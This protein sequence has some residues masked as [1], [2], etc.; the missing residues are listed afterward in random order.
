MKK[1]SKLLAI[2]LAVACIISLVACAANNSDGDASG[3]ASANASSDASNDATSA[4]KSIAEILA[5]KNDI[6][7]IDETKPVGGVYQI[8]TKEGV[9]SMA[10]HPEASF[11]ILCSIDMEGEKLTPIGDEKTPFTGRIDGGYFT[12][13]NFTIEEPTSDG[14][15]G[16]IGVNKGTVSNLTFKN[17]KI[18]TTANTK[19]VGLLAGTS[20]G[21]LLRNSSEECSVEVAKLAEGAYVGQVAGICEGELQDNIICLDT[22][23][24]SDSSATIGGIAAKITNA[25]VD[26]CEAHGKVDITGG[27]N[28]TVGLFAGESADSSFK[29]ASYISTYNKVD[30]ALYETLIA[31]ETNVT[32]EG[33]SCVDNDKPE[34]SAEVAEKRQLVCDIMDQLCLIPWRVRQNLRHS[35]T[36]QLSSCHGIYNANVQ[37]YGIP[38]N[39]KSCSIY[40]AKYIIDDEGYLKDWVYD[41]GDFDTF[42]VYFGSDCSGTVMRALSAVTTQVESA[43]TRD[44]FPTAGKGTVAVGDWVY[45]Y[46][47]GHYTSETI[48]DIG[49]QAIYECYAQARYG[50]ITDYQIEAGGHVR[51]IVEDPVVV[52]FED[53]TIDG[54]RSYIIESE[55]GATE[56]RYADPTKEYSSCRSHWKYTFAAL[57]IDGALPITLPEF[58]TGEFVDPAVELQDHVDYSGYIGICNGTV[59]SNLQLD[60]VFM[61]I[62]DKDGN[63][64]FNQVMFTKVARALEE[65]TSV[66]RSMCTTFDLQRFAYPIAQAGVEFTSG[67]TY[68]VKLTAGLSNEVEYDVATYQVEF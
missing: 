31:K 2:I 41:A 5:E 39:H 1:I 48:N 4:T 20:T 66:E 3:D 45:T 43:N 14:N 47:N 6:S 29:N 18:V 44:M 8:H 67:E 40:R 51:M 7:K 35:C 28:K 10:Q 56:Q 33:C 15:M 50:D 49:E 68:N 65:G 25:T 53:G 46:V 54:A 26:A 55:E 24:T 58:V 38:Y 61:T 23:C 21:K 57:V 52:R 22:T 13:S 34:L 30:G 59:K 42:D 11:T 27:A 36:C 19:A 63:E 64:L 9:K 60:R 37:Y 12:I 16:F 62:T 17:V 32:R